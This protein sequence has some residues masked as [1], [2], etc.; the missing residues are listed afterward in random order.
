MTAA[1]D[2]EVWNLTELAVCHLLPLCLTTH[3]LPTPVCFCDCGTIE[4]SKPISVCIRSTFIPYLEGGKK[5]EAHSA[6]QNWGVDGGG[7]REGGILKRDGFSTNS[8][9]PQCFELAGCSM[10]GYSKALGQRCERSGFRPSFNNGNNQLVMN[11]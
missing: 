2:Q 7:G 1:S 3:P 4:P 6:S 11:I 10:E 5:K 8:Q 9:S